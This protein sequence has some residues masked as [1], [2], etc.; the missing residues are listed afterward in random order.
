MAAFFAG[1]IM[2]AEIFAGVSTGSGFTVTQLSDNSLADLSPKTAANATDA[3]VVW[4]QGAV[5]GVDLN[6]AANPLSFDG[7][8]VFSRYASGWSAMTEIMELDAGTRVAA[9]DAAM[10]SDGA[11]LVAIELDRGN[12]AEL[13]YALIDAQGDVT[14]IQNGEKGAAPQVALVTVNGGERFLIGYRSETTDAAGN[15]VPDYSFTGFETDGQSDPLL[16]FSAGIANPGTGFRFLKGESGIDESGIIWQ[17]SDIILEENGARTSNTLHI[18]RFVESGAGFALSAAKEL[19][20]DASGDLIPAF[21]AYINNGAVSAAV[22]HVDTDGINGTIQSATDVFANEIIVSAPIYTGEIAAPA[23]EFPVSFNIVNAGASSITK[24]EITMDGETTTFDSLAFAPLAVGEYSANYAPPATAG[25]TSISIKAYFADSTDY[26][27]EATANIAAADVA[28]KVLA[29]EED[30]TG[31][32][33][34]IAGLTN[35]AQFAL[36]SNS[37]VSLGLYADSLGGQ[38][39]AGTTPYRLSA[40]DIANINEG[41]MATAKFA[42]P[43]GSDIYAVASADGD[44]NPVNNTAFIQ[45][46]SAPEESPVIPERP[47]PSGGSGEKAPAPPVNNVPAETPLT[48]SKARL[49]YISGADR[50]LTSVAISRQGWPSADTVILAP[51]G[52]NNL[53]DALA[54]APLAGQE[55]APILLCVGGL[56]PAVIAEIERLGAKKVY[57]VGALSETVIEALKAALPGLTVE[58]LRGANRFETAALINAKVQNPKGTFIVGYNAIADAVSAASYA[59][60]NGYLIQIAQPDG[61][62][63]TDHY[64]LPTDHYILGGPALVGDVAGATR[65]YGPDRYATNKAIREALTFEYTNIYTADG[66]TLV[67]ALTGSALAAKTKAAI[68]LIPAGDPTGADFGGITPE[69]MVYAFGGGK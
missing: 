34:A 7:R 21:D 53:I 23:V 32:R 41:G 38:A 16:S 19:V 29:I 54:V 50:V 8:L 42:L 47:T 17:T 13:V 65:L 25:A 35:E 11:A 4:Q 46:A 58:T 49:S 55:N 62:L 22:L 27:Y 31:Q 33:S 69:T 68:V 37:A 61:T 63:T 12:G 57:A 60:A 14:L 5:M 10:A 6:N 24:L 2:P 15:V 44:G 20:S 64:P 51:G 59:A 40:A 26:T 18:A 3:L 45:N 52:A 9:Y 43:A 39:V 30:G 67:D 48:V 66:A 28:V 1:V 56:D 36:A